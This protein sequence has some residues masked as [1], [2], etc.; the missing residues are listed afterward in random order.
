MRAI[1]LVVGLLLLIGGGLLVG[2][3]IELGGKDDVLRIGDK[4]V[5]VGDGGIRVT[6]RGEQGRNLGI[7]LL[8][9]GGVGV[10]VGALKKK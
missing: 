5:A 8:V 1:L 2:G 7:L 4:A 6:D 3:L 9:L 10:T